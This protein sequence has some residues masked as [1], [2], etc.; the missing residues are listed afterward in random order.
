MA[1]RDGRIW[2]TAARRA[3]LSLAPV[4][5]LRDPRARLVL[6]SGTLLFTELLLIR[7]IPSTV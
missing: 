6:T 3:L 1:T 4:P 2:M 7:S 5:C